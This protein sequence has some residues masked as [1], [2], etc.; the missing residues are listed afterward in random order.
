MY[1]KGY[2]YANTREHSNRTLYTAMLKHLAAVDTMTFKQPNLRRQITYRDKFAPPK[3][4]DQFIQDPLGWLQLWDTF[5]SL[6]M[7]ED[8]QLTIVA[9][10][11]AYLGADTLPSLLPNKPEVDPYRYQSLDRMFTLRK[12]LPTVH[13][14]TAKLNTGFPSDHF[15]LIS[16]IKLKLGANLAKVVKPPRL[17]YTAAQEVRN[18]FNDSLKQ[19]LSA[20]HSQSNVPRHTNNFHTYHHLHGRFRQQGEMYSQHASGMGICK[21]EGWGSGQRRQGGQ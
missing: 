11:R 14:V 7:N 18:K 8:D 10:I 1:G 20:D 16:S 15:L 13:S 5:Q 21:V 12:W 19:Q 3:S 6:P 2:Q 17:E 9:D 4:W